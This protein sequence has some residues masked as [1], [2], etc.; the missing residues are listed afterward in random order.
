MEE[1]KQSFKEGLKNWMS[2]D[3]RQSRA[4][5]LKSISSYIIIGIILLI[6]LFVVPVIS[7]GIAAEDFGFY[8]PK[9]KG[10]WIIFW[11]IRIGTV[12]GN[13]AIFFL[14]KQQAKINMKNNENYKKANLLLNKMNG[15]QGFIPRSPSKMNKNEYLVK[16][17]T[18]TVFTAAESII[19]GSL[20]LGFDFM[21]FLSCLTSSVTAVAFGWWTMVKNEVYWSEEYLRYAE[22]VVEKQKVAENGQEELNNGN[23]M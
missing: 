16:G 5:F 15:K 4:D 12:I 17:I 3:A 9:T 14:F 1:N 8:L 13:L 18:I 10:G 20:A 23:P 19:I 11:C 6:V 2:P 7:G 21:T 22:Y